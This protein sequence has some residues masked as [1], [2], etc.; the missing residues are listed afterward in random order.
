MARE[1]SQPAGERRRR[2]V[3]RRRGR[4]VEAAGGL[5]PSGRAAASG[6]RAEPSAA[7][8]LFPTLFEGWNEGSRQV[9]HQPPP[10]G[11]GSM[12]Q[13]AGLRPD[14]TSR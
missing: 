1:A 5:V 3:R 8:R 13:M 14:R 11:N 9:D 6:S 2:P 4:H 12:L 10:N 7:R